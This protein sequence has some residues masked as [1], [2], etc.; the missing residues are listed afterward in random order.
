M[1]G[2]RW[3]SSVRKGGWAE[4][5]GGVGQSTEERALDVSVRERKS[6]AWMSVLFSV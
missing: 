5:G 4:G 2:L 1:F 3:V 6:M